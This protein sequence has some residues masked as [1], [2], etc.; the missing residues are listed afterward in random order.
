MTWGEIPKA[1]AR[2]PV[3]EGKRMKIAI[4]GAG[5]TGAYLAR[6]LGNEGHHVDLFDR[7]VKTRC[8]FRPCAWG[9]SRGFSE[10]ISRAGL[11]S[12]RY[13]LVESDSVTI[14]DV[15]VGGEL[16]TFDKPRLI[17]D[18]R[19]KTP[20]ISGWPPAARSYERII[21]ATGVSRAVLPA[22]QDDLIL[23]CVQYRVR[24]TKPLGNRIELTSVGYAW[25]FPLGHN[26]YH[27]GCGS[28]VMDPTR[29]IEQTGWLTG[30]AGQRRIICS[31][32]STIRVSSPH[33]SLPFV[34]AVDGC[35]VWGVGEAIGCVAPLA[36]DGI[37]P[38]LQSAQ[39][40]LK[41]WDNAERYKKA[42][43]RE[44]RW[45]KEE[46]RVVD[47]LRSGDALELKDAWVLKKNSRRMGMN[48]RVKDARMLMKNL[49][50]SR[51]AQ[52]ASL[53]SPS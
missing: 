38:G 7:P 19:G 43:L 29:I 34:A 20:I 40:L 49:G 36:G 28:L 50:Q 8:G 4:I 31:C 5:I 41:W 46:R 10:L 52:T 14:D 13:L 12:S 53:T 26:E 22:V 15:D 27:I 16:M 24:T 45:M 2:L 6:L 48:V 25:I 44:F 1:P 33:H 3:H 9:T 35:E 17:T 42:I 18:L 51:Q 47:K 30:T 37:V 23:P 39:L 21:D 32:S 11:D